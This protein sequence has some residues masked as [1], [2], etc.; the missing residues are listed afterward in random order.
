MQQPSPENGLP[1]FARMEAA[2]LV[3][4]QAAN[5]AAGTYHLTLPEIAYVVEGVLSDFRGS[6]LAF[7]AAQYQQAVTPEAEEPKT[8]MVD[9]PNGR[10][11]VEVKP[12][13]EPEAKAS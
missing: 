4:T 11:R 10:G 1:Q 6:A 8:R 13:S 9:N 7:S 3:V 5:G 2:R 12:A